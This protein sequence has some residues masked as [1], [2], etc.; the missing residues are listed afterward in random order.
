MPKLSVIT[1]NYND[2]KGLEKTIQSVISQTACDYEFIVIDG[3]STDN[4]IE[5]IESYCDKITLWLSEK[6]KGIYDAQNKGILKAIGEYFIFLNS[7]D[8]FFDE[9][10]VARFCDFEKSNSNKMIYGKTNIID[11][12][13]S[14]RILNP[15]KKLE[16]NFW[17]ANTLNH[18]AVFTH[19][20]LF[21]KYGAF[22]TE[23]NF[24]SDFEH[25][26]RL[27]VK[28]PAEFVYFNEVICDYDNTGL[29]SKGE[30]HKQIIKERYSIIKLY[31]SKLEYKAMR[32]A[33]LQTLALNR[34]CMII[35]TENDFLRT[36][37]RPFYKLFHYCWNKPS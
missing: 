22:S 21:E 6:D 13:G 16:L 26:F 5:I 14:I 32:K 4:S 35:V 10:V 15:P 7:G 12:D 9:N 31:V 28:E 3:G 33:Y 18:Q 37:L 23:Y 27:F 34:K 1:I 17:Y 25:L 36:V 19:Q 8:C 2:S 29:T 20:S 30:F 24:A 11:A